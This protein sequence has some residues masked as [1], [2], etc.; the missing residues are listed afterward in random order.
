M[1]H[2]Q[3]ESAL[4]HEVVL[5]VLAHLQKGE[6]DDAIAYFADTFSFNDRGMSWNSQ[7]HGD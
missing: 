6:F 4:Q 5:A 1:N 7:T 3:V 2:L